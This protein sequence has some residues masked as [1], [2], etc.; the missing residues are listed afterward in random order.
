METPQFGYR[1]PWLGWLNF[2]ILRWFF[3]RLAY[4]V[5]CGNRLIK[6][7]IIFCVPWRW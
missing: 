6:W 1:Y 7:S 5:C 2:F 3:I 4:E